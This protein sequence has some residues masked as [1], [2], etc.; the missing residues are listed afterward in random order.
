MKLEAARTLAAT[1]AGAVDRLLAELADQTRTAID[2]IRR[3]A[4]QLRP[5]ALDQLGLVGALSQDARRLA[6]TTAVYEVSA[7]S[8]MEGLPAAVE[9]AAYRIGLE[10]LTNVAHHSGATRA[11]LDLSL[12]DDS[13]LVEV[14]DNGRGTQTTER[15]GVGLT[16]MRERAEELGGRLQLGEA[17]EG[18]V[19]VRAW[20][21]LS[22]AHGHA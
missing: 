10:A 2:D 8:A 21:P 13:L 18:G 20:L 4:Y 11:W 1:D 16:S 22:E 3:V 5:P 14:R 7:A 15:S 17:P 12:T 19:S 6:P 9:V